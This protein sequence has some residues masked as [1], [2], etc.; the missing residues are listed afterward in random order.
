M[1]KRSNK[2]IIF[3]LIL[4]TLIYY[5]PGII[6]PRDF[7]VED[8]A[9][10]AEV[11]QEMVHEDQ[12]LVPHLNGHFYPDKPP[13]YFWLSAVPSLLLGEISP[14][15]MMIISWLSTLGCVIACFYFTKKLFNNNRTAIL[16]ALTF[17]SIFLTITCGLIVRMDMLMTFFIILSLFY[18]HEGYTKN[19][20]NYYY[21]F[22]IFSGFAILTKGPFGFTFSFFPAIALL[23]QKKEFSKVF[24]LLRHPGFLVMVLMVFS[25]LAAAWLAGHEDFVH[26]LFFKQ[27]AGRAVNS[28]SHKEPFYFY[29][30][31]LPIVLLPWTP[32]IPRAT[33]KIHAVNSDGLKLLFWWFTLGL[34][35]VSFVSGKLFI[36]LLPIMPPV[37]I[38]LGYF[39]SQ[40]F[41]NKIKAGKTFILEG[42]LAALLT[43]GLFGV[44]PFVTQ[45]FPVVKHYNFF[46]MAYIFIPLTILSII[47]SIMKKCRVHFITLFIGMWFFVLIGSQVIV[48]QLDPL[49]SGRKI[50]NEV[51]K[52]I[53]QGNSVATYKVRRGIFNFYANSKFTE[54]QKDD[55]INYLE[56]PDNVLIAKE[57][58]FRKKGH[59]FGDG[60]DALSRHEIANE[61][62]VVLRKLKSADAER[63]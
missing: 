60:V 38:I 25:W 8:E 39:F 40:L 24:K 2:Q 3:F 50:G 46:I 26:N 59:I 51:K 52:Y 49:F 56:N 16:S 63:K 41:E 13:V 32:F 7:W 14:F 10:Y 15:S 31:L 44:I 48:P 30:M 61:K 9:R 5:I 17:M 42:I 35:T 47:L 45:N 53:E 23:I 1:E 36:Y 11:M 43:F 37:A 57:N 34:I 6:S 22:Y 28:F 58:D 54:L 12:W 21:L 29:L 4:I 55:L 62:Y 33:K 20:S 18:F 19:N 27:I